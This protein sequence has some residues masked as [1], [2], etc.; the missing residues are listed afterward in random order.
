MGNSLTFKVCGLDGGVDPVLGEALEG[1]VEDVVED[2]VVR[3]DDG[4]VGARAEVHVHAGHARHRV[5]DRPVQDHR[6]H[7]VGYHARRARQHLPD[8]DMVKVVL[9]LQNSLQAHAI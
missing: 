6:H 4:A 1:V 7:R 8:G 2:V 3:D 9:K 5:L